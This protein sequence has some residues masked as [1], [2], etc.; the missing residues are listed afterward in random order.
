[1]STFFTII[2]AL[3][4][5][6]YVLVSLFKGN[7]KKVE[8]SAHL[9]WHIPWF[10]LVYVLLMYLLHFKTGFRD[11]SFVS[12][13]DEE[14]RMEMVFFLYCV[15]MWN[16][17]A[18]PLLRL[19][20][21]Q[22]KLLAGYRSLF[23][24]K[25]PDK[26]KV[27]PFPYYLD[28]ENKVRAKVGQVFYR[29]MMK[30]LIILITVVYVVLFLVAEFA[31]VRFYAVS[32][33]GMLSLIPMVDYYIFLCAEAPVEKKGESQSVA[34][35]QSD[36]NELWKLY[37]KVFDNYT[38]A[39]RHALTEEERKKNQADK[40]NN[41]DDWEDM[42]K[43]FSE[44][45]RDGIILNCD[46][47]T[48]FVK[49]EP[50]FDHVEKNGRFVLIAIDVPNHFIGNDDRTYVDEIA[51][52][53]GTIIRKDFS[54]Y[55]G[56][57]SVESLNNSVV[58]A[59]LSLVS[60][61]GLYKE[62]MEKIGLIVVV[63]I[64]DKNMSNMYESRRFS[65]VLQT[66]NPDYQ[67]LFLSPYCREVQPSI[68]NSWLTSAETPVEKAMRQFPNSERQ[69]YIGYN[70]EDY[71]ERFGKLLVSRPPEPL[72]SGS[73]MAALALSSMVKGRSKPVTPI[74]YL[75]LAY[76]N[77]VESKEEVGKYVLILND[78]YRIAAKD[79]NENI[80]NHLLP[81][82]RIEEDQILSVVY[83]RD[84]N[85]PAVYAKWQHL[86]NKE[87]FTIVLSKPYLFRD[88]FNDNHFFFVKAPFAAIQPSLCKSRITLA[89]VLLKLLQHAEMEEEELCNLLLFYY[90]SSEI[91]SV[92]TLIND[93][94]ATYFNRNFTGLLVT[95]DE[96]V[97]DGEKYKHHIKYRLK[98]YGDNN[99]RFLDMVT[100][101]DESGNVLFDVLRDLMEQNYAVGQTHMFSGRPYQIRDY[102]PR[103]KTLN[104]SR[105]NNSEKDIVFYR[106]SMR[107]VI[108]GERIPIKEMN[109]KELK[110]KVWRH[111]DTDQ[112]LSIV[113]EGF[114]TGV[115]VHTT[116]WYEF[117]KY[118]LYGYIKTEATANPRV[119]SSGKVLKLSLKFLPQSRYL[120]RI[121]DIRKGLQLLLYEAMQSVFPH[122]AQYLIISS[123]GEG[124]PDLP[125]IF[126]RL[127]CGDSKEE[128]VL[129]YYFIEDAHIDLGLI[130]ALAKT[131][132]VWYIFQYLYD[133][134]TWLTEGESLASSFL[135]Y[136]RDEVPSYLD[137]ELLIDFIKD[138]YEDGK[139]LQRVVQDRQD[140][141]GQ[142]DR[143]AQQVREDECD[144]LA[145]DASGQY[146]AVYEKVK[147][148]FRDYL[149]VDFGW[150]PHKPQLVA[151][152]KK[153]SAEG[154]NKADFVFSA[155][156]R[157]MTYI[158][159]NN[160][161]S[162]KKVKKT[163]KDLVE[164]LAVWTDLFLSEKNGDATVAWRRSACLTK[165]N[166]YGRGLKYILYKCPENPYAYI[167]RVAKGL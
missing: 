147:T 50:I 25:R 71:G 54:V 55:G 162:F 31:E 82:E 65:Y 117:S 126:N 81:V 45:H 6:A 119:Y 15:G 60:E 149:G 92:S 115:E 151:A 48:A 8:T 102:N 28:E 47:A 57:S 136:G 103:T 74:H 127:E 43:L 67:L 89:I 128:G 14:Y 32:A 105:V 77:A 145:V 94:F 76:S 40:V 141:Q 37:T 73:E 62:W 30:M 160:N 143:Q 96:V 112:E 22:N 144:F 27:M 167:Q 131:E 125:W 97:F 157:E 163:N 70:Y 42:R 72:C 5:L 13:N 111:R 138:F 4:T 33:L 158:W 66:V 1:M 135:K 52:K 116:D 87:N 79:I 29:R 156:V 75:E 21:L 16:F 114:E 20:V 152:M 35:G 85:A 59:P 7:R 44:N 106:P 161:D 100:V 46:L 51:D 148:M 109:P 140:R 90:E 61:Q 2:I 53:L 129:T 63:N 24:S 19:D 134:L 155:M 10:A 130:G 3:L 11:W 133:Y 88:Y 123:L 26:D 9:W 84:N 58:L 17:V 153:H 36:F 93:L 78:D 107:V 99:Q 108:D 41:D 118:D 64:F 120:K 166:A 113:F 38:V 121:D 34:P 164:G 98:L 18:K 95:S 69:F 56:E 83:D 86:G 49:L 101:K 104:V 146:N 137:F 165:D 124:D 68:A 154:M 110:P 12:G 91:K 159:E 139:A 142:L 132:T 80:Q 122:H 23:A 39:W 150:I